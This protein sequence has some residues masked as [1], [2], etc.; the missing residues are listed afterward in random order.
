M[1]DSDFGPPP[2]GP[3]G[4]GGEPGATRRATAQ[5]PNRNP[6]VTALVVA[7]ALLLVVATLANFWTEVLWY[8]SVGYTGVFST[9]LVTKVLL[10]LVGGL[11]TAAMVWSSIHFAYRSRPIYA[12]SPDT[13]A[14]EH[15]RELVEPMRRTATVAAPLAVGW[16]RAQRHTPSCCP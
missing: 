11:L 10:G 4:D 9:Q 1:S 14:M 5:R 12:P 15:Y 6:L 7:G 16:D 2:K 13:Q 8:Q 3:F